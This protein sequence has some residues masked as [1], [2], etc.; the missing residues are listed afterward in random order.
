MK[1]FL[2]S[3]NL[4]KPKIDQWVCNVKEWKRSSCFWFAP[5]GWDSVAFGYVDEDHGS[6]VTQIRF[7]FTFLFHGKRH[8]PS[9]QSKEEPSSTAFGPSHGLKGGVT[10]VWHFSQTACLS[11]SVLLQSSFPHCVCQEENEVAD[12]SQVIISETEEVKSRKC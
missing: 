10:E 3:S 4:D 6:S 8:N 5:C 11:H 7:I 1:A 12:P 2:N 9:R